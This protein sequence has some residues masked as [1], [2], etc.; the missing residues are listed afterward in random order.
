[1]SHDESHPHGDL[2]REQGA[3]DG[4]PRENVQGMAPLLLRLRRA[5]VRARGRITFERILDTTAALLDEVGVERLSTNLIAS[6]AGV[7]IA[8]V[9][10]YFPNKLSVVCALFD[11]QMRKRAGD[12][13]AMLAAP[14]VA[15][16]WR[17]V[18]DALVDAL[19]AARGEQP[20]NTALRRAMLS[21]P[22]LRRIHEDMSRDAAQLVAR[23]IAARQHVTGQDAEVVARCAIELLS[24]LLDLAESES[25]PQRPRY[26]DEARRALKA[27]LE[28][29]FEP[30]G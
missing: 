26:R 16:D 11:H 12:A 9:Y 27:Y 3:A 13:L 4:Q 24:A 30:A 7:N 20:G 14:E 28:P 21:S 29:C 23:W 8:T 18:A 22:E 19:Y 6:R 17:A 15:A 25:V 1:M 2:P 5:P 10:K